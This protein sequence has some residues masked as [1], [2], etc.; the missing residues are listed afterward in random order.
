MKFSYFAM[1]KTSIRFGV[2]EAFVSGLEFRLFVLIC[3]YPARH[4]QRQDRDRSS[5]KI[6]DR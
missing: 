1:I 6:D 2:S 5:G 4:C 3:R